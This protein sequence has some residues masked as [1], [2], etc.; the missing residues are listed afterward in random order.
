MRVVEVQENTS[1]VGI[2]AL[3]INGE[4][5]HLNGYEKVFLACGPL[6]SFRILASSKIVVNTG[7][8]KDSATFFLPLIALPR[9]SASFKSTFG[10][11]QLFVRLGRA[12]TTPSSQYQLY[13]YSDE[14]ISRAQG[15]LPFGKFIPKSI[16]EFFLS[17]M[18]IGIGYLDGEVS[19]SILMTV[20][21]NGS[22]HSQLNPAGITIKERNQ[23][24][25]DSIKRLSKS[26]RG[27]GLFPLRFLKQIA[28][29][30]EGVHF[31]SWLPMGGGSDLLGRPNG[32]RNIHVVDSSVLPSIAPGPI[33][34][35]IMANARRI[36][37]EAVR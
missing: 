26:I 4:K 13:E 31:G 35:T 5:N 9:I 33:T 21:E 22:I 36:A 34:F 37:E 14:L 2:L 8:L 15:A 23:R 20:V 7:Y 27:R 16:L 32:C 12:G 11:S 29:P 24:I 3:D 10:L 1:D 6:E 25:Q 19:P 18:L 28:L 17:K 30:G